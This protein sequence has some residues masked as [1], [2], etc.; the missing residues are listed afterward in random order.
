MN[1]GDL[2]AVYLQGFALSAGLIIAIGVQNAFVLRQGLRREHVFL[3]ATICFLSD[4]LLIAFGCAGFGTLVQAHPLLVSG[5][6]WIGAA[7]LLV[8]GARS[9]WA[10]LRSQAL[11]AAAVTAPISRGKVIAS[12]L[13]LTWLNPHVY[14]DT[15]LLVGGLAGRRLLRGSLAQPAGAD[16]P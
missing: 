10:A 15:V 16:L 12:V 14:L 13:A 3:V 2:P 9:A 11:E 6:R 4:A 1:V 7:F 8:Y 5:V